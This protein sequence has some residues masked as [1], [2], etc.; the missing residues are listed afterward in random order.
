[1]T[2]REVNEWV[3]RATVLMETQQTLIDELRGENAVLRMELEKA[4][5][6][7]DSINRLAELQ[8]ETLGVLRGRVVLQ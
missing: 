4:R 1:V 8:T 5:S 2:A 3:A 7:R 6:V